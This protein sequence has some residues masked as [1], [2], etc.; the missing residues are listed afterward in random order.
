MDK[1]SLA[2]KIYLQQK[3]FSLPSLTTHCEEVLKQFE[4]S[5]DLMETMSKKQWKTFVCDIIEKKNATDL[6][7]MMKP[8]KKINLNDMEDESFEVKKYMKELSYDDALLKFRLRGNVLKTIKT[9]FKSD[10]SYSRELWSCEKCSL[11]DS[12]FH[13]QYKCTE[14]DDLRK[15]LNFDN[16]GDVV[17]FFRKVLERR[18][19]EVE[20]SEV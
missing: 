13:V 10:K 2:N 16:D 1:Q 19:R 3:N 12:T 7:M 18:E 20:E 17:S 9:H 4:M 14:Y 15:N 11:L 5:L 6:I 8:Y